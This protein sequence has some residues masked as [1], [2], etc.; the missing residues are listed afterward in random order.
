[1]TQLSTVSHPSK[2][3]VLYS[4]RILPLSTISSQSTIGLL[5]HWDSSIERLAKIKVKGVYLSVLS[6]LGGKKVTVIKEVGEGG[7]AL[8]ETMLLLRNMSNILD[9]I[10]QD[11]YRT[12][13][14]HFVLIT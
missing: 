1:M 11:R 5:G 14:T 13:I 10:T 2:T 7:S 8:E 6:N 9:T 3:L 4:M 12:V